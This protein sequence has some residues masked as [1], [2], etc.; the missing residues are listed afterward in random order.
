M[1]KEVEFSDEEVEFL[2]GF[3]GKGTFADSPDD[4]EIFRSIQQK[5]GN[6]PTDMRDGLFEWTV[7]L[8]ADRIDDIKEME[9]ILAYALVNYAADIIEIMEIY[10]GDVTATD[11]ELDRRDDSE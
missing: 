3:F 10:P 5:L 1:A 8:R 9:N 7:V 11:Y 6:T 2:K 4:D